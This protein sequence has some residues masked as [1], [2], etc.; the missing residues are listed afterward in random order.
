MT[1]P[2][3]A[4]IIEIVTMFSPQHAKYRILQQITET[5]S[6]LV[7]VFEVYDISLGLAVNEYVALDNIDLVDDYQGPMRR[8]MIRC[9]NGKVV[10]VPLRKSMFNAEID[11]LKIKRL[12]QFLELSD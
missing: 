6:P 7:A 5:Y 3:E 9:L 2:T 8:D 12:S 10:V 1:Q 4:Q 11:H